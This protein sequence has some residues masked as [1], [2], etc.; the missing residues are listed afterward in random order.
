MEF[1][2]L[3]WLREV[4]VNG[5]VNLWMKVDGEGCKK[6]ICERIQ[7]CGRRAWKDDTKREEEYVRMTESQ[8]NSNFAD[9][10]VGARA[11]LIVRGG[12]E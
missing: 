6:Y 2:Y 3:M 8:R 1:V 7:E 11:R 12:W 5:M 9:G 10:R 4:S